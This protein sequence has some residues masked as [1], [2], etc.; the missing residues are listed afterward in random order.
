MSGMDEFDKRYTKLMEH[1]DQA[2]DRA[3]LTLSSRPLSE[4]EIQQQVQLR[5]LTRRHRA[6]LVAA[7]ALAPDPELPEYRLA[8]D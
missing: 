3:K 2:L 1:A 8:Q 4:S 5:A 7:G 6:Q